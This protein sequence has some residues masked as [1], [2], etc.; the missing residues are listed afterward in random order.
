MQTSRSADVV[1]VDAGEAAARA[2]VVLESWFWE[3]SWRCGRIANA[4]RIEGY[5]LQC[6]REV[7]GKR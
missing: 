1:E 3:Y 6:W 2:W 5:S 7:L 4:G